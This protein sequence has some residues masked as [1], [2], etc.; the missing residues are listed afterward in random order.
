ML[1]V[2][3]RVGAHINGLFIRPD[4][5]AIITGFPEM[6][7]VRNVAVTDLERDGLAAAARE[8][9]GVARVA[10]GPAKAPR[11]RFGSVFAI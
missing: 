8:R 5:E 1:E 10:R 3:T 11:H 4:L 7:M 2:A 6:A 9:R